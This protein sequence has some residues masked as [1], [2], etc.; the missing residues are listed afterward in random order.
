MKDKPQYQPTGGSRVGLPRLC[1]ALMIPQIPQNLSSFCG[2]IKILL[3]LHI[4]L[5]T[6]EEF[7][8]SLGLNHVAFPT[9]LLI[10]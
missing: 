6:R 1:G 2:T 3:V 5:G 8:F 9:F 10:S 7:W 4:H